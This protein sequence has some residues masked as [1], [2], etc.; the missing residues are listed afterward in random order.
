MYTS[1]DQTI[2]NKPNLSFGLSRAIL[3]ITTIN[4]VVS[5]G[6]NFFRGFCRV[7]QWQIRILYRRCDF[8]NSRRNLY[9]C[10]LY[11]LGCEIFREI[12]RIFF[13]NWHKLNSYCKARFY[14]LL[15]SCHLSSHS[16]FYIICN[17]IFFSGSPTMPQPG[18][19]IRDCRS[20]FL[21]KKLYWL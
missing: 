7:W 6:T 21:E 14:K 4:L 3:L 8:F 10:L 11:E 5:L 13:L 15:F 12:F 19:K 20:T 16:A 1:C 17:Q 2:L 9:G 18:K